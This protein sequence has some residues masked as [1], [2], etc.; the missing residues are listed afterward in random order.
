MGIDDAAAGRRWWTPPARVRAFVARHE[1]LLW[2]LHSLYVLALGAAIMWLGARHYGWLRYAGFYLFFIWVSSLFLAEIVNRR[3]GTWW[4][5][6][7]LAVNYVNKNFYQQLLF[8]ILPIY[9]GSTTPGSGNIVFVVLLAASAIVS[10]LD[11]V[12]DRVLSVKRRLAAWFFAFNLFAVVGVALPVV[13]GV[14]NQHALRLATL[15]AVAGYAT[16]AWRVSRFR[17]G[18]TWVGIAAGAVVVLLASEY[19]RPF[20]PP[21]PLTLSGT[22]FGTGFDPSTRR[23][24]GALSSLP[25]SF[26]GRVYAATAVRAPLGLRDRVELRWFR[27]GRLIW[28][29]AAHDV[30][31]GRAEG[32]RLWSAVTLPPG[33]ATAA[34]RLDVITASGQLIGRAWL[35]TRP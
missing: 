17:R 11:L 4:G 8:F 10:T 23:V 35:P 22:Q 25:P 28:A 31:G 2:W 15:A 9:A 18:S 14:S 19:A 16:L 20:V 33:A 24:T 34:L 3:E 29:S 13:V 21:A 1:T 26:E 7:R 12:Y 27:D 30:R 5:R 32:F 6:A